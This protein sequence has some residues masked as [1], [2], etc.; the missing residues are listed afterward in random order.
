M[1]GQPA[2]RS[3]YSFILDPYCLVYKSD[4]SHHAL[5]LHIKHLFSR[6]SILIYLE[7]YGRYGTP[8]LMVNLVRQSE[9]QAR[10]KVIGS[11]FGPAIDY[12][13]QFL[14]KDKMVDYFEWDYKK[15]I[16]FLFIFGYDSFQ[17]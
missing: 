11:Q 5:Q 6:Y 15:G 3:I 4:P 1:T 14:P 17:K 7:T 8:C 2:I 10:E 13:N 12:I 16:L 9:T